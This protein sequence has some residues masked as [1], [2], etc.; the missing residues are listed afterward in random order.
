MRIGSKNRRFALLRTD[1]TAAVVI[2]SVSGGMPPMADMNSWRPLVPQHWRVSASKNQLESGD[3][4][5]GSMYSGLR[6]SRRVAPVARLTPNRSMLADS[7]GA[8]SPIASLPSLV[9]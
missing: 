6:V 5:I 2:V 3:E 9:Q 4:S 1:D 7:D 8:L